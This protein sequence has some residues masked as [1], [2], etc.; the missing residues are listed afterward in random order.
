MIL[1]LLAGP[2][3]A[4]TAQEGQAA[5]GDESATDEPLFEITIPPALMPTVL[6]KINLERHELSPG[7]EA[8]IGIENEAIRGK[9]LYLDE[10]ELVVTPMVGAPAWRGGEAAGGN[11]E[12]AHA[13]SP[14]G[15]SAGDAVHRLSRARFE[16][17]ESTTPDEDAALVL[18]QVE[19][20]VLG[21]SA[22]GRGGEPACTAESLL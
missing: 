19:S 4:A 6:G 22:G 14:V 21:Q 20:G 2:G 10:G 8:S 18:A 12:V 11:P 13:G 1:A 7:F 5:A 9:S 16:P 3:V 15:L 17:G